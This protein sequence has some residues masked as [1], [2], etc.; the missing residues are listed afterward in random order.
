MVCLGV[1]GFQHVRALTVSLRVS[2]IHYRCERPLSSIVTL[3]MR[4]SSYNPAALIRRMAL[5]TRFV[6][7]MLQEAGKHWSMMTAQPKN[8]AYRILTEPSIEGE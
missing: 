3:N 8:R 1:Y 6:K 2:H 4:Q 5:F 7:D